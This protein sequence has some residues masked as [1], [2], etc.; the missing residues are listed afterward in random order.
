M[1]ESGTPPPNKPLE[2]AAPDRSPSASTGCLVLSVLLAAGAA[3]PAGL[4][5]YIFL[6][7]HRWILGLVGIGVPVLA[8]GLA[9]GMRPQGIMRVVAVMIVA[10]ATI[11]LAVYFLLG[12]LCGFPTS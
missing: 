9:I 11:G 4:M 8:A 2:Y 10:F 1:S 12:G 3:L 6:G 7:Q 5:A